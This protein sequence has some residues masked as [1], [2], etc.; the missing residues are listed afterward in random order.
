MCALPELIDIES[1]T[2][3]DVS[4]KITA[5]VIELSIG[6]RQRTAR[7]SAQRCL[8]DLLLMFRLVGRIVLFPSWP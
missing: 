5:V 6:G 4:A 3:L 7:S 2:A 1:Q 8:W